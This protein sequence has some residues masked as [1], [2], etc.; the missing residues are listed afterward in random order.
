M[1]IMLVGVAMH[2]PYIFSILCFLYFLYF[3]LSLSLCA[4][5][6]C[7]SRD[8]L[9]EQLMREVVELKARISELEEQGWA[10]QELIGKLRERQMQLDA[11]ID[12]YKEIA[13]QTCN[14][15]NTTGRVYIH[16]TLEHYLLRMCGVLCIHV[17]ISDMMICVFVGECAVEEG[18]GG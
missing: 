10:D 14:V 15:S 3:L 5:L 13:E 18:L 9:I 11:E 6:V 8:Q 16:N 7:V 1:C 12:E 2:P 17:C 4:C